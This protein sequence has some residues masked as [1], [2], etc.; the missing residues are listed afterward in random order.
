MGQLHAVPQQLECLGSP[1]R[2]PGRGA[3][4]DYG[5]GMFEPPWRAVEHREALAEKFEAAPA[6]C[7]QGERAQGSPD[8]AWRAPGARQGHFLGGE[9]PR[10]FAVA[11]SRQRQREE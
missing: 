2:P 11:G 6:P 7:D 3:E 1:S 8:G 10:P 5:A 4:L 9:R